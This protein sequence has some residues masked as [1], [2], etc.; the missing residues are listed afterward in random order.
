VFE[1]QFKYYLLILLCGVGLISGCS[2][3][4]TKPLDLVNP[5]IGTDYFAHAYPGAVVPLGMIQLSPDIDTVGWNWKSGYHYTGHS[6][7]GFSHLHSTGGGGDL[8]LMA[9]TGDKI[10]TRPGPR[11]NPDEG[12]R[13]RFSHNQEK[14]SPGYYEVLLKDYDI[15]AELTLTPRVGLH[16]YT[17]P[18]SRNA[19]ILLDLEHGVRNPVKQ[20]HLK[21]DLE[22]NEIEGFRISVNGSKVFF[23][24]QFNKDFSSFGT[25]DNST[26]QHESDVETKYPFKTSETGKNIGAFV[27]YHPAD[28][29]QVLVKVGI[30]FVS[31]DGARN[32]IKKELPDWD[33]E[34]VKSEARTRW[35][36]ELNKI[37]VEGGTHKQK[38]TFYT[39]LYRTLEYQMISNDVDGKYRGMDGKVYSLDKGDFYPKFQA[40]D[41]YRSE[42]PLMTLLEPDHVLDMIRSIILKYKHFGWLPAQ[43]SRN[44][45][46]EDMIGDHLVPIVTDAYIKGINKVYKI[47]DAYEA[48]KK[49]ALYYPENLDSSFARSGLKYYKEFGYIPASRVT[50]SVSKTLEYSYDDWC[51]AQI[52]RKLNKDNDYKLFARRAQNYKNLF[53]KNTKFMRPRNFDGSWLKPCKG[54]SPVV[55]TDGYNQYYDCFDP[56]YVGVS[57][58]RHYT[59]SNAWQYLWSV[60]QDIQGLIDLMGGREKFI[61]KLDTFFTMTPEI[62]G[63]KYIGVV[64]TIGQ[65][66]HGNEPSH[67]VAYLYDYAGQPWKTQKYVREI[68]K[69][70]YGPEA[71]G[72]PGNADMGAMSGWYV[73]SA[74]GFY[75]V[76]P[77]SSTYVI[78]SPI[79]NRVTILVNNQTDSKDFVIK[80][81]NATSNNKY[82][83]S[84]TLN[85]KTLNKTWIK[86]SDIIHGGTLTFNMSDLP[87]KH[88]ATDLDAAPPSLTKH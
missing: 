9:T 52:A 61:D 19:Q 34:R 68:M 16:R 59:E 24:I 46:G 69:Y 32:N 78:G 51:I 30:S 22:N 65:Y 83:N 6:I 84:A 57:P 36:K 44:I 55:K 88:W 28:G 29:D 72:I 11:N 33:F 31:I 20:A 47:E 77:G 37:H 12:Y 86:H 25:W 56:L 2:I 3:S 21:F 82:I 63:P 58:Y 81:V 50:E 42:Q 64:G 39:A 49:K 38:I 54:K 73:F 66:V 80:G 35:N 76:S 8:M 17:F 7:M 41:T 5:F 1:Y 13:S 40:W 87:N 10:M 75:P 27:R 85:G 26:H 15:N 18:N 23:V 53:D 70:Y 14:A 71:Q 48:I 45:F 74:M 43:H 67:H 4:D 79:F 60:Q 62:T